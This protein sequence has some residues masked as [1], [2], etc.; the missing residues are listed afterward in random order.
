M[1]GTN[2]LP[3]ALSIAIADANGLSSGS[4]IAMAAPTEIFSAPFSHI[5]AKNH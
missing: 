3:M 2:E 4:S 5:L 1:D